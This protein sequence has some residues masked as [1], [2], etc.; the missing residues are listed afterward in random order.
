LLAIIDK[1]LYYVIYKISLRGNSTFKKE[2][3]EMKGKEEISE[4]I[5][6]SLLE[7]DRKELKRMVREI[8]KALEKGP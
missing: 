4:I 6:K 3:S 7:G 2:E 5:K 8:E 1:S